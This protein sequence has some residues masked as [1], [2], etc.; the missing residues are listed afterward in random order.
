MLHTICGIFQTAFWFDSL[1]LLHVGAKSALLRHFFAKNAIRSAPLLL[2]S[3]P[4]PLRSRWR[5]RR[6]TDAAYPLRVLRWAPVW[7]RAR[8]WRLHLFW[9]Y[10]P[11]K[12]PPNSLKIRAFGGFYFMASLLNTSNMLTTAQVAGGKCGGSLPPHPSQESIKLRMR[13]RTP[14]SAAIFLQFSISCCVLSLST[15]VIT[16]SGT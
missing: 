10:S 15:M 14:S 1:H 6:L 2:L 9:R 3:K 13:S 4:D 16:T 7:V 11:Y 8:T 5:L 12:N